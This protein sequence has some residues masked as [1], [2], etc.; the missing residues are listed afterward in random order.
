[1]RDPLRG[2][3]RTEAHAFAATGAHLALSA[4][5]KLARPRR[6]HLASHRVERA[7]RRVHLALGATS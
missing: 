1:M 6:V 4:T 2:L 7:R 5:S 3:P